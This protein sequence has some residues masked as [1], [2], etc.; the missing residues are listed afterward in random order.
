MIDYVR[1]SKRRAVPGLGIE[2]FALLAS[3]EGPVRIG[4]EDVE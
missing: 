3:K 1:N 2:F 4:G